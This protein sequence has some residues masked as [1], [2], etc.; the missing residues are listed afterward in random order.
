MNRTHWV[1]KSADE[2]VITVNIRKIPDIKP[3]ST[4]LLFVTIF[5]TF[6]LLTDD[7]MSSLKMTGLRCSLVVNLN[8][9]AK[10]SKRT[11]NCLEYPMNSW[12]QIPPLYQHGVSVFSVHCHDPFSH[13][14]LI[15]WKFLNQDE[16]LRLR[17]PDMIN[18][19][20][21]E[22]NFEGKQSNEKCCRQ[23]CGLLNLL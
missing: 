19:C 4:K 10:S 11:A 1:E 7:R 5:I 8:F 12:L 16:Q 17:K 3:E 18:D 9:D 15:S 23:A 20:L 21:V 6:H 22:A 14:E 2:P 13:E